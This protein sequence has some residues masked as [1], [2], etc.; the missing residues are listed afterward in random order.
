MPL[1]IIIGTVGGDA[2]GGDEREGKGVGVCKIGSERST[3]SGSA[4][5]ETDRGQ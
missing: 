5:G 2:T 1:R 4:D 3:R